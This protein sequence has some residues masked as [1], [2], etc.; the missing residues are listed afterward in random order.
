MA[1][2]AAAGRK[3]P[4]PRGMQAFGN[5]MNPPPPPPPPADPKKMA[6]PPLSGRMNDPMIP[7]PFGKAGAPAVRE[8]RD[9]RLASCLASE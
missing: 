1:E 5:G 2:G 7:P 9:A 8:G 3:G 6:V 4:P